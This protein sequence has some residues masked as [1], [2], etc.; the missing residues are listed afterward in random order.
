MKGWAPLWAYGLAG[1]LLVSSLRCSAWGFISPSGA[2]FGALHSEQNQC[3][4][5]QRQGPGVV[6]GS[7]GWSRRCLS[8]LT[9]SPTSGGTL[10]LS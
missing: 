3:L 10:F 4:R 5:G 7:R 1:G 6:T 9:T 2:L 8:L